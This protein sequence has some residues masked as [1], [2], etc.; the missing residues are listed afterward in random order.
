MQVCFFED[1]ALSRFHPLTLTRPVDEL[2]CGALT[3]REKWLNHLETD[4]FTRTDRKPVTDYYP[5]NPQP[6]AEDV[7]WINSRCLPDSELAKKIRGLR[8]GQVI[9]VG[10]VSVAARTSA[11]DTRQAPDF[12]TLRKQHTDAGSL[13]NGAPDLFLSN[14]EQIA[15]DLQW[16]NS[17]RS[18]SARISSHAIMEEPDRIF[19]EDGARIGPSAVIDAS[20]GPVIIQEGA[21]VMASSF[22]Q[23]PAVI[24]PGSVIKAG[25]R[26]YKECTIGPVCKVGGELS[27]IIMQGYSNKAHDG[28]LGNSII[29]EWCNLGADTTSS[30]L[31]NNYS[32][33][34]LRDWETGENFDTGLQFCGT[35]MG[36]HTKTSINTMLNTGSQFGVSCNII[37]G[38]FPPTF[39][40][41]FSW[42]GVDQV[43]VYRVEK[44][45]E[46]ARRIM[47]RRNIDL[48]PDYEK[49]LRHI[50]E[51]RE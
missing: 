40:P 10:G 15:E 19:T 28:Y 21:E 27:N 12:T 41:S 8:D 7:I 2:R 38:K 3:L 24:G 30:N 31:K 45:L 17:Q 29:G 34:R 14:G 20:G 48:T 43:Y 50:F 6:E 26:M 13:L 47:Q 35:I 5:V 32:L 22:V 44:A 23:G 36:D 51:Q 33:I 4:W 42:V 49:M 18:S 37:A 1:E 9:E 39:L 46:T 11:K 16:M 25:T